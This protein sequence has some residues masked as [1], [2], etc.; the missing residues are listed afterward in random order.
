MHFNFPDER[1]QFCLWTQPFKRI[2]VELSSC[3]HLVWKFCNCTHPSLFPS[4]HSKGKLDCI[5][6]QPFSPDL[7]VFKEESWSKRK[8]S[9]SLLFIWCSTQFVRTL[10]GWQRDRKKKRAINA[11]RVCQA[12]KFSRTGRNYG[13]SKTAKI[14][15]KSACAALFSGRRDNPSEAGQRWQHRA[16][17]DLRWKPQ[18]ACVS[19]I[20]TQLTINLILLHFF[21]F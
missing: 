5:C 17:A 18:I 11:W 6:V 1:V 9:S 2:H 14:T 3:P 12:F 10:Q 4:F 8:F 7:H 16:N 21:F 13:P 15:I 20:G 19:A